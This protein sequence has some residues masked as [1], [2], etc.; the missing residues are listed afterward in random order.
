M[1]DG[2]VPY[3]SSHLPQ[4]ASET[5]VLSD[6]SVHQRP[7]VTSEVERLLRRHADCS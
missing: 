1:G 5:V 2:V 7:V 6:H 3:W 4:A